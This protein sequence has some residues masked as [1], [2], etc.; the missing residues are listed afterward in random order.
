MDNSLRTHYSIIIPHH[1]IPE[2]LERCLQSIPVREDTQVIVVDDCSRQA[3]QEKLKGLERIYPHV[4][5]VYSDKCGGAGKARNTGLDLASGTYLIFAD[6]DDYFSDNFNTIL[7]RFDT[8]KEDIVYFRSKSV[9]SNDPSVSL[10]NL[11]WMDSIFENYFKTM[12]ESEIR[13]GIHNPWAKFFRSDFIRNLGIRFEER[14]YSNDIFFVVSAGCH[15]ERIKVENDSLYYYTS[16]ED[17]L[18]SH[19]AEKDGELEI[20]AE[21]AFNAS[22]I[23][24]QAGYHLHYMPSTFF[25][26]RLFHENKK[27]Y[28]HYLKNAPL[29]YRSRWDAITQVRW[30][31]PG[32]AGKIWVYIY[33]LICLLG[34]K[35]S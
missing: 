16:R 13:C 17:S 33:S 3:V 10:S 32:F 19:F 4:Q 24:K 20:R 9:L 12:D 11:N 14:P 23:I 26:S 27:L 1:D 29:A 35:Q 2:L 21:A 15:A 8:Y 6:A 7:D 22:I 34:F 18:T 31:E 28:R 25:Y 5:F 30:M